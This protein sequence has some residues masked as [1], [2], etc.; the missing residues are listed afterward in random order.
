MLAGKHLR[1]AQKTKHATTRTSKLAQSRV[2]EKPMA[3][4]LSKDQKAFADL[5]DAR[6]H[7]GAKAIRGRHRVAF[8]AVRPLVEVGLARGHTIKATWEALRD[9]GRLSMTYESFRMHCRRARLGEDTASVPPRPVTH[10]DKAR[11]APARAAQATP[12]RPAEKPATTDQPRSFQH[13]RVPQK[14]EIYG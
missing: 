7:D 10:A 6:A 5:L 14:K 3:D 4:N 11:V 9:T 2:Q 13:D 8:I 12:P 1:H